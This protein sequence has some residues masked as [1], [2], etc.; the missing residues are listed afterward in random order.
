MLIDNFKFQMKSKKCLDNKDLA[1]VDS[2]N[3]KSKKSAQTVV[4]DSL[5]ELTKSSIPATN[6]SDLDQHNAPLKSI[7]QQ[8]Q[9]IQPVS[10]LN[11]HIF[12]PS[13]YPFW[14][15]LAIK[16]WCHS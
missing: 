16:H 8:S 14:L 3:T 11:V 9:I 2:P 1:I 10:N 15:V 4:S 13:N 5:F 7:N 12:T 6:K